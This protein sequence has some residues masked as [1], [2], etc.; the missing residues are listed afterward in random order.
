MFEI[1]PVPE[2]ESGEHVEN[3]ANRKSSGSSYEEEATT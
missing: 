3:R 1:K 2:P